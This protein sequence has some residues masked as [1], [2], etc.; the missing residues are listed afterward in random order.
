MPAI[1]SENGYS[2]DVRLHLQVGG[3]L[4]RVAQ[5]GDGFL[6]LREPCEAPPQTPANVI[7]AVDDEEI[8]Y[9]VVLTEGILWNVDFV[10]FIDLGDCKLVSATGEICTRTGPVRVQR[11]THPNPNRAR[12][13]FS[14]PSPE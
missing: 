3:R 12:L 5:V 14:P 11:G 9:P 8:H 2:A 10:E 6:I 13:L 1:Q 4:V 7:V